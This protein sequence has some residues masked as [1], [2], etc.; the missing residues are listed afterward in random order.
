VI[1]ASGNSGRSFAPHLHYQLE[2]ASGRVLDPFE[3]LRSE[4]RVL[5]AAEQAAFNA[6]RARL[7]AVLSAPM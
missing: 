3:V 6:A 7:D 5:P 1:A 2:D 4:R